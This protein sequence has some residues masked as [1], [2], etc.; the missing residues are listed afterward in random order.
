MV[1]LLVTNTAARV[2]AFRS[3]HSGHFFALAQNYYSKLAL[4]LPG[5]CRQ[6]FDQKWVLMNPVA[7]DSPL[8]SMLVSGSRSCRRAT[9]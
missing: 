5:W 7:C 1:G 9:P 8:H 3:A 6:A 4:A 2:G